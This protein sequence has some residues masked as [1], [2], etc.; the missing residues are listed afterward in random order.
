MEKFYLNPKV[1]YQ[2]LA[3][4][5]VKNLFHANTVLTSLTFIRQKALLSRGFVETN[6]L[7]QTRQKSDKEDNQFNVWDDVFLDGLD[8]HSRYTRANHYGPVLFVL[9]LE[10][11]LSPSL[12]YLLVTKNNPMYWRIGDSWEDRYYETEKGIE[13]DY[14][15]GKLDSKVMFTFRSP[16]TY[17][18]LNKYVEFIGLDK[19]D[20]LVKIRDEEK[21]VGDNAFEKIR[22]A[23]DENGLRHINLKFRHE[24]RLTWCGCHFYYPYLHTSDQGEFRKRFGTVVKSA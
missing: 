22:E 8:L 13:S 10:L 15:T 14:L 9:K 11:L 20:V 18:K 7:V 17:I 21:N 5:G 12:P 19:P 4:K 16:E 3:D 6:N 2:T 24:R 1:V 23:M